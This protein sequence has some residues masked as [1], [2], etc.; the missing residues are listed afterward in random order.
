MVC[1]KILCSESENGKM[2]LIDDFK[3]LKPSKGDWRVADVDQNHIWDGVDHYPL[4]A[5]V[6]SR[7][8]AD[9][10]VFAYH[11][12]TSFV[13]EVERLR[14]DVESLQGRISLYATES[15]VLTK[16]NSEHEGTIKTVG[17]LLREVIEAIDSGDLFTQEDAIKKAREFLVCWE[18]NEERG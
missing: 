8:D 16:A 4:C 10:I 3:L 18:Y 11:H 12:F 14:K 5:E 2:G 17:K 7:S 9:F 15:D 6:R 1:L 13:Y